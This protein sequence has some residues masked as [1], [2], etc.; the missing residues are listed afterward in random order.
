MRSARQ[1][2]SLGAAAALI[3]FLVACASIGPPV[4]PSLELPKP[5]A[6]LRAV[7][8]G[9]R[10][11]LTW[12]VPVQT[13][14]RQN[15]HHL[16]DTNICRSFD[17]VVNQC[18]TPVGSFK[19]DSLALLQKQPRGLKLQANFTDTLSTDLEQQNATRTIG[20]AV[21]VLNSRG[22]GAGISNQ[23]RVALAPTLPPPAD[24]KAEVSS[25]GILLTWT[26]VAPPQTMPDI[27]YRYRLFRRSLEKAGDLRLGEVECPANRFED[28]TFEWQKSYDYR[29]AIVTFA[30]LGKDSQLCPGKPFGEAPAIGDCIITI[31]GED[32]PAQRVFAN[33]VYAPAVPSGLQAVF[34]GA[35]QPAF[36]D[37]LW[38]PDTDPDLAGYNVFRHEEGGHPEKIN[39]TLVKAPAFRDE[40]VVQ[41]KTY[42]Y[43]V[44]AV[45]MRG[46]E[47]GRSAEASEQI[48]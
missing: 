33:D 23:V 7:R 9:D 46:N 26:C 37:L 21:E 28:H 30:K 36:V 2:L 15:V 24:F 4:P 29:I 16:G 1:L 3:C 35:G 20:Y 47:S 10:V 25:G 40:P 43:S 32:S 48:P 19:T 13:I 45:D 44:S 18:G 41:G 11:F 14:D 6:D 17:S 8:K 27:S 38:A 34:S 42:W 31:E 12:A 39:A 22:R 5:P